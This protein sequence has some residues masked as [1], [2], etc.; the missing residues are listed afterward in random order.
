MPPQP[1]P[2]SLKR[3]EKALVKQQREFLKLNSMLI[4][5]LSIASALGTSFDGAR[6]VYTSFGY[7]KTPTYE[8]YKNFYD[9]EGIA[10]RVVDAVSDETWRE[11]P[12]IIPKGETKENA[13][14]DPIEAQKQFSE[15]A[16][17]DTILLWQALNDLDAAL[18]VS[19]YGLLFFGMPGDYDKPVNS[20]EIKFVQVF[21]EGNSEIERTSLVTDKESERF[22]LPEYY[23]LKFGDDI[24][25]LTSERVHW[26]RVLHVKEGRSRSRLYGQPRLLR[27]LNRLYDLE[28]IVGSSSEAFWK[29]IYRGM[30][31]TAKEGVTMPKKG[32]DEYKAMQDE[33]DE[34]EHGLRRYMRLMGLEVQDLEG[35]P[36]DGRSQFDLLIAYIAGS[37]S[38]PQRILL[39]SERGELA[40]S[41]DDAN[42]ADYIRARQANFAE[43][44]IL[45]PLL[46]RLDDFGLVTLPKEGFDVVWPN[47]F[48]L[49]DLEKANLAGTVA[50]ALTSVTGGAP[51]LAMPIKVFTKRYLNYEPS[52]EEQAEMDEAA[53]DAAEAE[54][55]FEAGKAEDLT[56]EEAKGNAVKVRANTGRR[57]LSDMVAHLNEY[58]NSAMVAFRIPDNLRTELQKTY[59]IMDDATRDELHVTLVYLGDL[60][61]LNMERVRAALAEYSRFAVPIKTKLA[62]LARFDSGGETDPVVC[63]LDSP[64]FPKIYSGLCDALDAFGVPYARDHGFIPHMTLAYLPAKKKTPQ[65]EI[66]PLELNFDTFYLVEGE[67]WT[68]YAMTGP[69]FQ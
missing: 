50:T 22:G 18:G 30:A 16:D 48:T 64:D 19:R 25:Q 51:E 17:N 53:E 54:A 3:R 60:R 63:T 40:S 20:G 37:T 1:T 2:A 69:V 65:I 55:E 52:E 23:N 15:I 36:I 12:Y 28:K 43:P 6:D 7:P 47:L 32:S 57:V 26:S 29:L 44:V 68:P 8:N 33:I 42:F 39:G 13:E 59:P 67:T 45:R 14:D 21:D 58:D 49:N 41:Q 31:F 46:R 62:G 24:Q 38:I 9:R 34:Y 10:T 56:D 5:R 27:I 35:K 4:S 66:Q 11:H 61:T